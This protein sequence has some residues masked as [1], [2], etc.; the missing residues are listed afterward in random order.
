MDDEEIPS[1]F[2][3]GSLQSGIALA[4][5]QRKLVACFIYSP[6]DHTSH[7]WEHYW[8]ANES[9]PTDIVSSDTPPLGLLLSEKAVLLK[10]ELGSQEAGF[11]KAFVDITKAPTMVVVHNGKVLEKVEGEVGREEFTERLL[12]AVGFGAGDQ[13]KREPEGPPDG[14]NEEDTT[15][16]TAQ[17]A[18]G[19]QSSTAQPGQ[20]QATTP[21]AASTT[22]GTPTQQA[23]SSAEIQAMLSERGK[24]LEAERLRREATEKAERIARSNARRK[25]EED[26]AAAEGY[27]GKG[28]QRATSDQKDKQQARDAWIF[29]QK[30]RKDEAKKE[31]E[32]ILAQIE[33]DKQERKAQA[34]RKKDAEAA[35]GAGAFSDMPTTYPSSVR[36]ARPTANHTTCALQVRLF[37]G[38]SIKGKFDP[39]ADIADAVRT[40]VKEASPE[41]GAD[42][43]F[44]FRQILA[45][46]PSRTIEISEEHQSLLELGLVPSAT[47]V[48]VLVAGATSAYASNSS[49]YVSSA[50]STASWAASGV[51]GLLGSAWSYVPS[52]GGGSGPYM[53][54]TGDE[55]DMSNVVGANMADSDS[56]PSGAAVRRV[57]GLGDRK[58]DDD[59]V[60]TF[61]NGNS[62]A[63]EGR[64]GDDQ[65]GKDDGK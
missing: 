49:G 2:H 55:Q 63:F 35:A 30:Q 8:L 25:E 58:K 32:R 4:I 38:S 43:P 53:G 39:N 7:V 42:I 31:R 54:G 46:R 3:Q 56:A 13:G 33:N 23:Q 44:T 21:A 14:L 62:S 20:A 22:S 6:D 52:L 10:M 61:Y 36:S 59:R 18:T 57:Q 37:D 1:L 64:K 47:L 5:Q 28:K 24:R 50:Y 27:D 11:L 12:K 16:S 29:Q 34:Q 41:G 40:W 65:D 9:Q 60:T 45:P 17:Q 19:G 48:L 51:F 26:A 15:D